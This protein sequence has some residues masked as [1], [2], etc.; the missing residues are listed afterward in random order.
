MS[1]PVCPRL[2]NNATGVVKQAIQK[3]DNERSS[4][5]SGCQFH[6]LP[7]HVLELQAAAREALGHALRKLR[8]WEV[9]PKVWNER[10]HMLQFEDW[11][12][13]R[14]L[15]AQKY[16][17]LLHL[18][19]NQL[20]T[21]RQRHDIGHKARRISSAQPKTG[22]CYTYCTTQS[23]WHPRENGELVSQLRTSLT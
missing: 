20:H 11:S 21:Q 18:I 5:L 2:C 6:G 10:A 7:V 12:R 8:R 14:I 4:S 3:E 22:K 13:F 1:K 16:A 17:N 23:Q 15:C 9:N 19:S